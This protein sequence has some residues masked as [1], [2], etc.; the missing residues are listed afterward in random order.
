M[1]SW[2]WACLRFPVLLEF[3]IACFNDYRE[4]QSGTGDRKIVV[5]FIMY[6]EMLFLLRVKE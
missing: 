4:Q 3:P 6:S 1:G 2:L 5:N